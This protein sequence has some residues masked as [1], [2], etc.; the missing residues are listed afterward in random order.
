MATPKFTVEFRYEVGGNTATVSYKNVWAVVYQP[1]PLGE[2]DADDLNTLL[3]G[4]DGAVR[5]GLK[6]IQ[7]DKD[8]GGETAK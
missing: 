6:K 1:W 7:K 4:I 8:Q 5:V 3:Q 2:T